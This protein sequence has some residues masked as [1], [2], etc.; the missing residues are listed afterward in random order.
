MELQFFRSYAEG[1]DMLGATHAQ[2]LTYYLHKFPPLSERVDSK[3]VEQWVLLGDPS[4]K[5]GGYG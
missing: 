2:G 5:I 4:L 1:V 3:I